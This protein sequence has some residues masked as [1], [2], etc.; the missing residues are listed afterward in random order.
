MTRKV[1]KDDD[2]NAIRAGDRVHF[3][4]GI[5][6]RSVNAEV[7]DRDGTLIVLTPSHNPRECRLD[8]LRSYVGNFWK[9]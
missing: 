6:G 2:G 9:A 3:G 7:V 4:Y 5:P 1:I 8:K